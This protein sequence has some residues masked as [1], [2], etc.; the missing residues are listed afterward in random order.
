MQ[1]TILKRPDNPPTFILEASG[2]YGKPPYDVEPK[3]MSRQNG[4]L[5][6]VDSAREFI[7]E[8]V[9]LMR[10]DTDHHIAHW[11]LT[12]DTFVTAPP[13]DD[14][15]VANY[16]DMTAQHDPQIDEKQWHMAYLQDGTECAWFTELWR[17]S[18][19]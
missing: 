19:P 9:R 10:Q 17:R 11:H 7:A 1:G 13:A 8:E 4:E 18:S 16:T 14:P 12:Q 15:L 5:I 2:H 3:D 6:F